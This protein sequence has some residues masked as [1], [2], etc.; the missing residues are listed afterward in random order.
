MKFEYKLVSI[1]D[2]DME[3][4]LNCLGEEE[5]E[6]VNIYNEILYFKRPKPYPPKNGCI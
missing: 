6:L 3:T 4:T 2:K 5:W 1:I